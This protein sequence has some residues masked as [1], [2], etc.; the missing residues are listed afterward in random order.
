MS[1]T[2]N[3]AFKNSRPTYGRSSGSTLGAKG[4]ALSRVARDDKK[5][6]DDGHMDM[7]QAMR[8]GAEG[9]RGRGAEGLA[10]ASCLRLGLVYL[11]PSS[12]VL[13]WKLRY[14]LLMLYLSLAWR[15]HFASKK[16]THLLGVCFDILDPYSNQCHILFGYPLTTIKISTKR[17]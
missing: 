2:L 12:Y 17:S 6:W 9:E 13:S 4:Q 14:P 8:Q 1:Y 3:S 15:P 16:M 5:N 7:Q 11:T 10:L